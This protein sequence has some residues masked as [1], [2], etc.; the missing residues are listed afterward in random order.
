M[1]I[2]SELEEIGRMLTSASMLVTVREEVASVM[3]EGFVVTDGSHQ[4]GCEGFEVAVRCGAEDE[5]VTRR[6]RE[7]LPDMDIERIAE[8]LIG[9]R[10]SR[11]TN[12]GK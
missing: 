12:G 3:K 9:L 6:L 5:V 8:G 1:D 10:S 11:R 4:D 7:R 2:F